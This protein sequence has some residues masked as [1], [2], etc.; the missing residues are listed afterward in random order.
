MT[1]THSVLA[2]LL[3]HVHTAESEL[4]APTEPDIADVR[5]MPVRFIKTQS[6][7]ADFDGTACL[8][9]TTITVTK[10]ESA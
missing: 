8:V 1:I 2:I 9:E 3:R 10:K 7:A 5:Q 4:R 6:D